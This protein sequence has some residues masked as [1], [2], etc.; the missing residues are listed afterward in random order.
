MFSDW[1]AQTSAPLELQLVLSFAGFALFLCWLSFGWPFG[2]AVQTWKGVIP[3]F[4]GVPATIFALMVTF[5]GQDIWESNRLAGRLVNQEREQLRT[6]QA[7]SGLNGATDTELQTRIRAYVE[8]VVGLE[9]KSMEDGEDAP[10]AEAALDALTRQAVKASPDPRYETA[11][12]DTVLRLRSA[13]EQRLSLAGDFPNTQK[14]NA[15]FVITFLTQLALAITHLE[16]ARTQLLA[17]AIFAA[18]AVV[19]LS[20]VAEFEKPFRAPNATSAG[21]LIELL[22]QN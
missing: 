12:V 4:V 5:L 8:A 6:L 2:R 15:A 19:S 3:T 10:E 11:L 20:L 14:W 13:R 1:L 17:Q 18:A 21:P 9:W 22:P 16:R 7:L